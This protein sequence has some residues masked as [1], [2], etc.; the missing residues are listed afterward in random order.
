M[1]FA[2]AGKAIL[3]VDTYLTLYSLYVRVR[4]NMRRI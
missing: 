3:S 1:E 2:H 4:Y